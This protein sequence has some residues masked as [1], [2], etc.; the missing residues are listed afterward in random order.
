[1]ASNDDIDSTNGVLTSRL[2]F[3]ASQGQAFQIAVD[4]FDAAQGQITLALDLQSVEPVKP[5]LGSPA[6][7]SDGSA[8]FIVIGAPAQRYTIRACAD[9][10]NWVAVGEVVTTN[11]TAVFLDAAATNHSRRFYR[12]TQP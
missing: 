11:G 6:I 8:T 10:T 7:L 5:S 12:A 1:M 4:G 3:D 9:W 2:T